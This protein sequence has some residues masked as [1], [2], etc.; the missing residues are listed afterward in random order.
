MKKRYFLVCTNVMTKEEIWRK[1]MNSFDEAAELW[2]KYTSVER[3]RP[4]G[5]HF[6]IEQCEERESA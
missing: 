3:R 5:Q 2:F 4:W 6:H 1:E